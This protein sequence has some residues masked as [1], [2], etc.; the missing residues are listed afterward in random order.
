MDGVLIE[1]KEW[2]YEALNKALGLFGC[3]ISHDEHLTTYDG[4]PTA[5][6]L[7]MLSADR[8]FP[9]SLHRFINEL[10]QEITLQ[11]VYARC[12]PLFIHE[13][14]LSN[15]KYSGYK[16]A[17]ASNSVRETVKLMMDRSQLARWIDFQ[18]SNQDI[19]L[20]KP[21]PDIYLA[22]CKKLECQPEECL[23]IEDNQN[24]IIAARSAGAHLMTVKEVNDVTYEGIIAKISE[25][26]SGEAQVI[27]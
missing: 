23:V 18:L 19:D 22:A 15:L 25:L 26:E 8:G 9:K 12:T 10:K 21:A 13:Y 6:K 27:G 20:P 5:K 16:I 1:A 4:L 14:A 2:H 3:Q 7:D 11:T 24:G 17:V